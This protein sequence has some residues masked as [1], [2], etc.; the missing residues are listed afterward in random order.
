MKNDTT[1]GD[2]V[3]NLSDR[4][5]HQL[6]GPFRGIGPFPKDCASLWEALEWAPVSEFQAGIAQAIKKRLVRF[7]YEMKCADG[8][9]RFVRLRATEIDEMEMRGVFRYLSRLL[10]AYIRDVDWARRRPDLEAQA[11]EETAAV[12]VEFDDGGDGKL[13]SMMREMRA[14]AC[15]RLRIVRKLRPR[16]RSGRPS[17]LPLPQ[18]VRQELKEL[19]SWLQLRWC[20]I[21]HAEDRA[22]RATEVAAFLVKLI[23]SAN[24]TVPELQKVLWPK[25][26]RRRVD[27][28]AVDLVA[29]AYRV[30]SRAVLYAKKPR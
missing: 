28:L 17:P 6:Y 21:R 30:S 22:A 13:Q 3:P 5:M 16:H 18:A 7:S 27:T 9:R 20:R 26:P 19:Q 1:G 15:K 14:G 23:P 10:L 4:V 11:L 12:M 2:D 24:L 25:A 8:V 29:A